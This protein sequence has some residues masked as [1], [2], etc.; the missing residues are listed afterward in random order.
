VD[1]EGEQPTIRNE[2]ERAGR[3][4]GPLASGGD[5]ALFVVN[6]DGTGLRQISPSG[7]RAYNPSWSPDGHL[8]VF[9]SE[10]PG[11]P[12]IYVVH[13][14]GSGFRSSPF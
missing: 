8:V 2:K 13:P 9:D 11:G 4:A 7:A 6:P 1:R 12:E 3:E 10:Y 5:S 14:D